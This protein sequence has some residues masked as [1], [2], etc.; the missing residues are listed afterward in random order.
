MST[1]DEVLVVALLAGSATGLGALPILVTSRIS[2]KAYDS[3]LGFAAGIMFGAAVFTLV[4]PGLEI[5]SMSAVLAGLAVGGVFLLGANRL[6]PHIHLLFDRERGEGKGRD[7]TPMD[8][9]ATVD[10]PEEPDVDDRVRKAVLIASAITIHN[11]PEGLAVGIAFASGQEGIGF[12][13]AVAIAVQNVPDGF[14][15][16]VP[17]NQAGVSKAKTILFTTLSGGV[18]EPLAAVVGFLLVEFVV[19]AFPLAAGVAAGAMMAVIFREMIPE[20]HAHGYADAATL[21]F[22]AGFAVMTFI[23]TTF[24]V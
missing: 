2:H 9:E 6:V 16:A 14:A 22:I 7:A 1:L 12:A 24:T 19:D 13:I 17:A 8:A 10:V 23:D 5:G 21:T 20:S 3:A 4:V 18:P 11:I 15:M